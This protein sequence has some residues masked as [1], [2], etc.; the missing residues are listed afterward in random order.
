MR[1]K[2]LKY[3]VSLFCSGIE[4]KD[5]VYSCSQLTSTDQPAEIDVK[6]V[7]PVNEI[8][9]P[10]PTVVPP[11][12]Q[13][14]TNK[15]FAPSAP[16]GAPKPIRA[17]LVSPPKSTSSPVPELP[18]FSSNVR[19]QAVTSKYFPSA[20]PPAPR[21][22]ANKVVTNSSSAPPPLVPIIPTF[23]RPQATTSKIFAPRTEE[24]NKGFLM[25]SEEEP[26]LT[27][28]CLRF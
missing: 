17:P 16:A 15:I 28:K 6:P 22:A 3:Y 1:Y 13:V 21:A 11:R 12:P 18:V 4:N 2:I 8:I 19:P 20:P 9:V 23:S 7:V 5:E 24:M 10:I 27:S 26:G 25:F 14:V